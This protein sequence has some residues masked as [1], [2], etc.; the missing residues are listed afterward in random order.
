MTKKPPRPIVPPPQALRMPPK[1]P[2]A[3]ALQQLDPPLPQALFERV[4]LAMAVHSAGRQP[5]IS[6]EGWKMI[7]E[8]N[9]IGEEW[10]EKNG[11]GDKSSR[12]PYGTSLRAFRNATGFFVLNKGTLWALRKC[13]AQL[14]EVEEWRATLSSERRSKLAN[15][16]E[17]WQ[18]FEED[19]SPS[20]PGG[21]RFRPT[22][23]KTRAARVTMADQLQA[24]WDLVESE[25]G[26]VDMLESVIADLAGQLTLKKAEALPRGL[27]RNIFP[28]LAADVQ[29]A[30]HDR[31]FGEGAK[32]DEP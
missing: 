1:L 31:L 32:G 4:Q 27:L 18:Q 30:L 22:G 21:P 23:K 11:K 2:E 15:P 24:A 19:S 9:E 16:I 17:V 7:A 20:R 29:E 10:A 12:G 14:D 28:H 26:K 8:A 5:N 25:R 13:M 6:W 3:R